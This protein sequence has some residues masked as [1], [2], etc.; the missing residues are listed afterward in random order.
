MTPPGPWTAIV[1]A[2]ARG[3]DDPFAAKL[4]VRHKCLIDVA[5]TAMIGRVVSALIH[6]Q[7]IGHVVVS[8]DDPDILDDV[9]S[10]GPLLA[11]G[12]LS[13][14]ASGDN[15]G[16]STQRAIAVSGARF[17]YLVTTA[18]HALLTPEMVA[19]FCA[20][21]KAAGTAITVALADGGLI[22]SVYP[23]AVRTY[24]RF[25]GAPASGCNL[26]G[27]MD[28][29][30]L[31]AVRFWSKLDRERKSP[32][33]LV[34]AFGLAPLMKYLTGRLGR[35]EAFARASKILGVPASAVDMPF[36]E[37]AIDVDKPDD[38]ALA[39][40]ILKARDSGV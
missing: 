20:R 5:G 13:A 16:E 36:A 37:A 24:I 39:E 8:I 4:G 2:G 14:S 12:R 27:L 3:P 31:A 23:N 32:L 33:K 29:R 25:A 11:D 26:Y 35:D 22:S 9:P 34:R 30:A 15:I 38:L 1:L 7:V 21:S 40:R 17:P 10:L 6:S 19:H 18:D 28:D